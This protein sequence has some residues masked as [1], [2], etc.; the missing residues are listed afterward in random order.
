MKILFISSIKVN[1]IGGGSLESRKIHFAL[2]KL[3]SSRDWEYRLISLDTNFNDKL[4]IN[5]SKNSYKDIKARIFGHSSYIIFEWK[6]I[7]RVVKNFKPDIIFLDGSRLGSFAKNIK[8]L[9][10]SIYIFGHFHNIECDY[11]ES[12]AD[13]YPLVFNNI[14]RLLEKRAV[15]NDEKMMLEKMDKG[16]FLNSRDVL[17]AKEIYSVVFNSSIIPVCLKDF[18]KKIKDKNR[19]SLN[20]VFLGSLWYGSNIEA[21]KWF[22]ENVWSEIHLEND[23]QLIIGGNS[24]DKNLLSYLN[25]FENIKVFP[26]FKDKSDIIYKN[27][28][29]IS[30]IQKGSG[31]KV[32]VAEALS[33]GIPVLASKE[34]L[35]GYEEAYNDKNNKNVLL[36]AESVED[37]LRY[38]NYFKDISIN[39]EM[40]RNVK[41]L[42]SSYYSL[43]RAVQQIEFL[44]SGIDNKEKEG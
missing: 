25:S 21:V 14:F 22:A 17:R 44:L 8:K 39:Y 13:S 29:F 36:K 1:G 5:L 28:L 19:Y 26:N 15:K 11:L 23:I 41:K 3:S 40:R 18:D 16:I 4:N 20:L 34:A 42:F 43:D 35:V 31:M 24:P 6:K 27:S 10:K 9:N 12:V 38:I 37:Y 30:P 2:N 7:K 32:K 33:M